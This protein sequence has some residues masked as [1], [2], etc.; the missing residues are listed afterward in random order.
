M[1]EEEKEGEYRIPREIREELSKGGKFKLECQ[2]SQSAEWQL[3]GEGK[4]VI[5]VQAILK[6]VIK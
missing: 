5:N 1:T 6:N 4:E 2:I 3:M